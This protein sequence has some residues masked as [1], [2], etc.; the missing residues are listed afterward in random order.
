M[1]L[2][3]NTSFRKPMQEYMFRLPERTGNPDDAIVK[4]TVYWVQDM[5]PRWGSHKSYNYQRKELF[6]FTNPD[7]EVQQRYR[8]RTGG[9]DPPELP[10]PGEAQAQA[11]GS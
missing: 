9:V 3:A 1:H 10:I 4:G 8:E 6:T 5:N 7:S 11:E 2:P